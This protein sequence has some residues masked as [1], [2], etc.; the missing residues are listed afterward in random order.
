[1]S[2]GR[3]THCSS[4]GFVAAQLDSIL[5]VGEDLNINLG[6]LGNLL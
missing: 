6:R 4:A 3:G 5:I 1:L 2:A